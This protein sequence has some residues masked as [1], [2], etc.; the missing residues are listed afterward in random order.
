MSPFH[1]EF[2][3]FYKVKG[4]SEACLRTGIGALPWI[5]AFFREIDSFNDK[6]THNLSEYVAKFGVDYLRRIPSRYWIHFGGRA[7]ATFR[8]VLET[9]DWQTILEAHPKGCME[10]QDVS[11]FHLDLYGAYIPGLCTGL[12]IR[13]EDL[14]KPLDPAR[15]PILTTLYSQGVKGLLDMAGSRYEYTP[16]GRY[17]SK[18]DLCFD[19]RRHLI[20]QGIEDARELHPRWFYEQT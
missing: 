1:N 10:L 6:T 2:I 8:E 14:G 15:Y 16:S 20:R 17:L 19:I 11:H 5:K 9:H 13:R 7:L 12:C 3:P 18:C 4:V